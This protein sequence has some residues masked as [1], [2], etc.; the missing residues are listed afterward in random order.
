MPSTRR[1]SARKIAVAWLRTLGLDAGVGEELPADL[2]GWAAYGFVAVPIV[3]GGSPG[4][5]VPMRNPV[6]QVD[7]WA[8]RPGSPVAPWGKAA[9]LAEQVM[10]RALTG[11]TYPPPQL[12]LPAGFAPARLLSLYPVTE[13]REIPNDGAGFAR[14]EIDLALHYTIG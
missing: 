11:V 12:V 14:L 2:D 7:C 13:P 6:V 9:D 3:A 10:A 4:V 5:D 1:P 8:C